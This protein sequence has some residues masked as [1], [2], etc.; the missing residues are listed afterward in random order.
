MSNKVSLTLILLWLLFSHVHLFCNFI[1]F[2]PPGSSVHEISQAGTLEWVTMPSSRGSSQPRDW[3]CAS[4]I[5]RQIL[6]HWRWKSRMNKLV[7][8]STF[9]KLISWHLAPSLPWQIDG[10]KKMQTVADFIFLSSKITAD[11]DCSHAIKRRLLLGRKT[12][13]T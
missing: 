10:E 8:S 6:Y 9:K 2:S 3:T 4:C 13:A 11:S 5:G 1:A 7:S 12:A